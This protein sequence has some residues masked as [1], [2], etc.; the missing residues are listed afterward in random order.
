MLSTLV[1]IA[2]VIGSGCVFN[3][4]ID[5]GL[6]KKMARTKRRALAS[7]VI[8]GTRALIYASLLGSLGFLIIGLYVNL[9]TL[10][11]GVLGLFF[12]I[13]AYSF[14][15]RRSSIGTIVGSISGATPIVAGYTAAT[16]QFDGAA[17]ILFM[18]LVIWQMPHFYAI[19]M[20]RIKDYREAGL[21]VLPLKKGMLKTKNTVVL[22]IAGFTLVSALL[23]LFGYTGYTFLVVM[24]VLGIT[25]QYKAFQGF[26]SNDDTKWARSMFLMSLVVIVGLSVMLSLDLLLP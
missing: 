3:N 2:L 22:Y 4:Y 25:W 11:V 9:L 23:T 16:N 5:R 15:K 10:L 8:S 26:T 19:A 13:V 7:G 18:I 17:F 12:Y 20:F 14:F 24:S 1:G 21:P 6:D